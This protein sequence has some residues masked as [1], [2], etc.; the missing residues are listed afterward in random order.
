M[1]D[2]ALTRREADL[3]CAALSADR[4]AATT[5]WQAWN[6][7][8]VL[9]QAPN[10]E[11]RLLP[12]AYANL[13]RVAPDLALPPKLRGKARA[14]FTYNRLICHESLPV[15]RA[16]AEH[17]PVIVA[18]GAAFCTRFNAWSFRQTGDVDIHVRRRD[19]RR[20]I[21]IMTAA[22][23]VPRYGMTVPSLKY[24]TPL[25]RSSWN[26]MRG[27]GDIDLHWRLLD[28][29][30]AKALADRFWGT[31]EAVDFFG[32][33]VRMPSPE[34][35]VVGS[36]HHGLAVGTRADALQ[37]LVDCWH[38]LP[39]C[40]RRKLAEAS[41]LSETT[42][43]ADALT[44]AYED[45]GLRRADRVLLPVHGGSKPPGAAGLRVRRDKFVIRN[46]PLYR[47]WETLGR[48]AALERLILRHFGPFSKPL[49]P[50]A[51]PRADYDLRDCTVI[52]EIGGPGWGWPEP[53]RTCFWSDQADNRLLVTVPE[54]QD[55]LAIFRVSAAA[56]HAPNGTV[57]VVVNGRR[58]GKIKFRKTDRTEFAIFIPRAHLFGRW[59]EFSF[60][61]VGFGARPFSTYSQRRCLPAVGLQ[62]VAAEG[63]AGIAVRERA[64]PLAIPR[65]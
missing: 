10:A 55:Y 40:D 30:D 18:K 1:P 26:L 31:A 36:L 51:E 45:A 41:T 13:S 38:W 11:L 9:E 17:A 24:R 57:K 8:V 65:S 25:R 15:L 48:K 21:D 61:P 44:R 46:R 50:S 32:A 63:A 37:T 23:W 20:T 12:T 47:L 22:G 5:A 19:L 39:L 2:F 52:D 28:C 64:R 4:T 3:V 29:A 43:F 27:K 42:D 6:H 59:I 35:S 49:A 54:L 56:K 16:L 58:A 7:A 14:T 34:F 33:T 53:E 62:V 60:R